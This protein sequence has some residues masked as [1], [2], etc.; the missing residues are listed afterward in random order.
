MLLFASRPHGV[1]W[2]GLVEPLLTA[3]DE[4]GVGTATELQV[5]QSLIV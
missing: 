2:D 5:A 4:V 1:E 3:V